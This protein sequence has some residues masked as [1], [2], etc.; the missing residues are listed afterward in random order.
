M[1]GAT[2]QKAQPRYGAYPICGPLRLLREFMHYFL[3]G[4]KALGA[5]VVLFDIVSLHVAFNGVH[6]DNPVTADET[7][8]FLVGRLADHFKKAQLQE[9]VRLRPDLI[10]EAPNRNLVYS[11]SSSNTCSG[12]ALLQTPEDKSLLFRAQPGVAV[13]WF[14]LGWITSESLVQGV[15]CQHKWDRLLM[16]RIG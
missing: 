11:Q 8:V 7:P 16:E 3:P 2:A 15:G 10:S 6:L 1:H 12:P 13:L 9:Q 4:A 5:F 14:S